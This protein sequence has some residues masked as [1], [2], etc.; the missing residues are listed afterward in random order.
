MKPLLHW[1]HLETLKAQKYSGPWKGMCL[2]LPRIVNL[3]SLS[4]LCQGLEGNSAGKLVTDK[5]RRIHYPIFIF[6]DRALMVPCLDWL[7]C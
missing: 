7:P 1:D 4:E 3:M 5:W 2:A 6:G